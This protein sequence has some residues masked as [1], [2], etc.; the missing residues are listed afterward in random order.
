M[1]LDAGNQVGF[2]DM[3][4]LLG[5]CNYVASTT[6]QRAG[7]DRWVCGPVKYLLVNWPSV[8]DWSSHHL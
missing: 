5:S 1:K 3:I 8:T 4:M 7:K 2:H 6:V